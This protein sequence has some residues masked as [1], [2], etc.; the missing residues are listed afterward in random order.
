[1][2]AYD[3]SRNQPTVSSDA[4][5]DVQYGYG[6]DQTQIFM[7]AYDLR[8]NQPQSLQMLKVMCSTDMD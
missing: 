4:K 5:G 3:L 2:I 8:R 7:I 1:M 6:L